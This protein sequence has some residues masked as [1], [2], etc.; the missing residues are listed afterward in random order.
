[1][2]SLRHFSFLLR[3][4]SRLCVLAVTFALTHSAIVLSRSQETR[5]TQDPA[6]YDLLIRDG[7]IVDGTGAP[8]FSAD[9]GIRNGRIA[10]L[11]RIAGA[12]ATRII[13]A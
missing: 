2:N 10:R 9:V 3:A 8:W 1:M 13:D 7:R 11:G 6:P 4:S 12:Q 5:Q